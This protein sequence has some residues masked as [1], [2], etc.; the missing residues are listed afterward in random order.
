M[1]QKYPSLGQH[2]PFLEPYLGEN[3]HCLV[4]L[5]KLIY[6]DNFGIL[7]NAERVPCVVSSRTIKSIITKHI[8]ILNTVNKVCH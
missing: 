1:N 7:C 3:T 6:R 4:S 2:F 5:L 8:S